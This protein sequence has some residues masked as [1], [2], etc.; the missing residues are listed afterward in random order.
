MI[1]WTSSTDTGRETGTVLFNDYAFSAF[2]FSWLDPLVRRNVGQKPKPTPVLIDVFSRECDVHDTEGL[3]H[4]LRHIGA[5]RN[6][7]MPLLGVIAA[8]TF[9]DDAWNAAKRSG[10]LAINWRSTCGKRTAKRH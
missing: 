10:L 5:N 9:T 1:G 4:R 6:A 7:R 3:V 2:S 8:H